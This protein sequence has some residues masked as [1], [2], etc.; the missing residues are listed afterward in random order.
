[1]SDI[2]R[3]GQGQ[4]KTGWLTH[5][6][7]Y[8]HDSGNEGNV[9]C[10]QPRLSSESPETKRRFANLVA[11]SPL[12][13]V[14]VPLRPRP[15]TDEELLRVHTP[16]YVARVKACGSGGGG[17]LDH[18]LHM[19][20][21]GHVICALSAGGVLAAME[22]VLAGTVDNAYALVRPPGHHAEADRGHG[23]CVYDNVSHGARTHFAAWTATHAHPAAPPGCGR[24]RGCAR[25]AAQPPPRRDRGH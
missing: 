1:M 4:R 25:A 13:D 17:Y 16:A 20:P 8:W 2:G 3:G 14:L 7:F 23:V 10:V 22:A 9:A 11:V 12:A 15:A 24:R 5:E 6:R 21:D 18:E 19:G